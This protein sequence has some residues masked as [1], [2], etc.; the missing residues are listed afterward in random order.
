MPKHLNDV[1]RSQLREH[2]EQEGGQQ[3][4]MVST[5]LCACVRLK[6]PF[7]ELPKDS[8][9]RV[10]VYSDSPLVFPR[11]KIPLQGEEPAATR[12]SWLSYLA[13]RQTSPASC[14]PRSIYASYSMVTRLSDDEFTLLSFT[15]ASDDVT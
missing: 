14:P 6:S 8:F 1:T 13:G 15:V 9:C 12:A 7:Q 3:D 2:G 10:I 11:F 4:I 5:V